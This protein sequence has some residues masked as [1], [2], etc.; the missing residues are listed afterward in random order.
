MDQAF[1]QIA[2]HSGPEPET[3]TPELKPVADEFLRLTPN[4]LRILVFMNV[5]EDFAKV[6]ADKIGVTAKAPEKKHIYRG[7]VKTSK[8]LTQ[9]DHQVWSAKGRKICVLISEGFSHSDFEAIKASMEADNAMVTVVPVSDKLGMIKSIEGKEVEV[10]KTFITSAPYFF[11]ALYVPG[12]IKSIESLMQV[13]KSFMFI[14][15]TF[16]H[17]KPIAFSAEAI[18]LYKMSN[19]NKMKNASELLKHNIFEEHGLIYQKA[20][21]NQ[22]DL[23]KLLVKA[24]AHHR[25]WKRMGEK[26]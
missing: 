13:P 20:G 24:V 1:E 8:A 5:D 21:Q 10:K 12:G 3:S 18:E 22:Q 15:E 26:L 2:L 11:D 9:F 14:E 6:L 23:G 25:H 7:S 4:A 16:R 19:L 17:N